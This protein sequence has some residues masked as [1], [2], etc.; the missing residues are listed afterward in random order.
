MQHSPTNVGENHKEVSSDN[1]LLDKSPTNPIQQKINDEPKSISERI[2]GND[3]EHPNTNQVQNEHIGLECAPMTMV[4][5]GKYIKSNELSSIT[6]LNLSHNNYS[7]LSLPTLPFLKEFNIS[8]NKFKK[9]P[10]MISSCTQLTKLDISNNNIKSLSLLKQHPTIR[11]LNIS[12]NHLTR[13]NF[14]NYLSASNLI[15]LDAT[16]NYISSPIDSGNFYCYAFPTIYFQKSPTLIIPNV[17]LGAINSTIDHV[18]LKQLGIKAI[19]SVGIRPHQSSE[20]NNLYL[21]MDDVPEAQLSSILPTSLLFI[22][23]NLKRNRSIL[24]HCECGISRSASILIAYIMKKNGVTYK[25][26]LK[27]VEQKRK[28]VMPNQGFSKQLQIFENEPFHFSEPDKKK[29]KRMSLFN[30]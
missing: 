1:T 20:F 15:S 2:D 4:S 5:F 6:C 3:T 21:S 13:L 27:T 8:H 7:T 24:I 14:D 18:Y 9:I 23:E 11:H 19:L 22:D 10:E 25:E 17:Y 12:N 16:N 26:A 29:K 30:K 28:C